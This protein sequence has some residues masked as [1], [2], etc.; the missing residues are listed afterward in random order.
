MRSLFRIFVSTEL[1][2]MAVIKEDFVMSFDFRKQIILL[3]LFC[4]VFSVTVQAGDDW[5]PVSSEEL[6]MKKGKV[7]ADADAEAIFWEVRINDAGQDLVMEHYIRVKILTERGRE[8]FSK[9]EIPY[10]KGVKIKDIEARVVRPDN[11]TVEITKNDIFDQEKVKLGDKKLNAKSF[12]VPNIEPGVILEYRYKE[13]H[14]YGSA[15]N[16][17]M[18]FQRDIPMQRVTYDFKP[19]ADGRPIEFNV[20][21]KFVKEKGDRYKIEMTDMPALKEEPNMPPE[22]EVRSWLLIYYDS[23]R[24]L[25]KSD[26]FWNRVGWLMAKIYDIKDTLKPGKKMRAA[27]EEIMGD[28]TTDEDKIK[29]LFDFCKTKVR[30]LNFDP[31]IT[32]DALDEIKNNKD[33]DD[34]YKK[35]QGKSFE[36]NKLFASLTDAAGFDTRLAFTGDRSEIFFNLNKT[37]ESFIHMA[38]VAVKLDNRWEYFDPGSPFQPYKTLAWFEEG[39]TALLLAYKDFIT[40]DL[41]MSSHDTSK[42]I[43]SGKFKLLEDGTLEGEA[44][45]LYTGH[46][47]YEKKMENYDLS[48]NA[49]EEALKEAIKA[50]MSTAELSEIVVENASDPENPFEYRYKIRVPNY[51]QVVGKRIFFQPGFFAHGS[52]PRFSA[53]ERKYDIYFD[54]PWSETEEIEIQLPEGYSLDNADTPPMIQDQGKIGYLNIKMFFDNSNRTLKYRRDFYFGNGGINFFS[55]KVYPVLKQLFDTYHQNDTHSIT[56]LKQTAE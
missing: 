45:I 33:D 38:G 3:T 1:P 7:E 32:E 18:D 5:R 35:L 27:A 39:T 24:N 10:R 22:D 30:N 48:A 15:D 29:R 44:R 8:K 19:G 54:F 23:K 42:A 40:V 56:L 41:Q 26:E 12:A 9:I 6:Q 13:T 50:R 49:R 55:V 46:L 34:T 43:R 52:Q 11:T 47:S 36:I 51:A 4:L 31:T 2:V 37:H 28:A 17:R 53:S 16:L 25:K 21:A 20:S 14:R